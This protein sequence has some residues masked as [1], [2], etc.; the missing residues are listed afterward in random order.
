MQVSGPS[1]SYMKR[2]IRL[3][4]SAGLV[5]LAMT[6]AACGSSGSGDSPPAGDI[7]PAANPAAATNSSATFRMGIQS[8]AANTLDPHKN[9]QSY[10]PI[11]FSPAY[12]TLIT[13]NRD[14]SLEANLATE[15]ADS[16]DGMDLTLTLRADVKFSDGTAFD[17]NVVKANIERGQKVEGSAVKE[18]LAGIT[19]V[20]VSS[21]TVAV[22][23][24]AAPSA[25]LPE[26]LA[27]PSGI[28][29]NPASFAGSQLDTKPAGTG[30]FIIDDYR[31]GSVAK[32][33]R[34]PNY[35]GAPAGVAHLELTAFT[36]A[37]AGNNA[38]ISGQLDAYQA[39]DAQSII[40]M[41]DANLS[42]HS[43]LGSV[44]EWVELN[45]GGKFKD[46]LVRQALAYASDRVALNQF[47][48]YG[49][50]AYQWA[51]PDSPTYD[52]SLGDVYS[53]DLAK[54]KD[55]LKQAG[56]PNGFDFTLWLQPKTYTNQSAEIMQ[57]QWAKAGFNVTIRPADS[58]SIIQSCFGDRVCDALSGPANLGPDLA[59]WAERML[60]PS[61][62]RNLSA[63]GLPGFDKL[64]T[65]ALTPSADR[66]A[67]M[68]ALQS[69]MSTAVPAVILRSQPTVYGLA[70][71]VAGFH[72]DTGVVPIYGSVT[73]SK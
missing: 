36:D 2:N 1:G 66:N 28:M 29:I 63:I 30:P 39:Y 8:G 44:F 70:K 73:I 62:P 31:V 4:I 6:V 47:A 13:Q 43:E 59:I 72:L 10:G 67:K 14:G 17:S 21:P 55:L 45:W 5:I 58:V 65:E 46:P 27:G 9:S 69:A 22:L 23:H 49:E 56:F 18:K 12:D 33:S 19:S 51:I 61:A 25:T 41:K 11:W 54:A 34:N 38:L 48:G 50:P 42:I 35:W 20:T 53:Y 16:S 3:R 68:S 40:T 32:Y 26:D 24:L 15:W 60:L 57:A 71:N 52:K 7:S 64:I 37:T